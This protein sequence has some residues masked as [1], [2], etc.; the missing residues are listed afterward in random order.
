[1]AAK[2][3]TSMGLRAI[4]GGA[5]PKKIERRDVILDAAL[6]IADR[7]GI[8]ALTL[9]KIESETGLS[10]PLVYRHFADKAEIIRGLVER[11][12]M[13]QT[14]EEATPEGARK[15]LEHAFGALYRNGRDHSALLTLLSSADALQLN[16]LHMT[17]RVLE[18]LGAAGLNA[19]E[20]G[21]AF[22]MLMAYTVGSM[23]LARGT[24]LTEEVL[25]EALPRLPSLL[26]AGPYLDPR[27]EQVFEKGLSALLDH[28]LA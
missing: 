8:E 22:H 5:M 3:S 21:H 4:L 11:L 23:L 1:M 2:G 18:V 15:W 17:E 6:L 20:S 28:I 24:Q 12:L 16:A 26:A 27:N 19:A 13:G 7:D 9:R 10:A 14:L 25:A